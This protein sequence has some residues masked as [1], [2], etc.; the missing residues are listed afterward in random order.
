MARKP[1]GLTLI[2]IA[3]AIAGAAGYA[4]QI[5]VPAVVGPDAFV[6]FAAFWSALYLVIS[7]LSGVQQEFTRATL[8]GL[9]ATASDLPVRNVQAH[10][11]TAQRHSAQPHTARNFGFVASALVFVIVTATGFLWVP[12]VLPGK[13]FALA[14]PLAFGAASYVLVATLCGTLYGIKRFAALAWLTSVDSVLRLIAISIALLM[15][16]DIIG[17]AWAIALPFPLTIVLVW[18][19]IR[20]GLVGASHVDSGLR[21]LGWNSLRTVIAGAATGVII[22]GF[23]FLVTVTSVGSDSVQLATLV[24]AVTL[25]RAPLIIPILALQ[26]YLVVRFRDAGPRFW[27]ELVAIVVGVAALAAVLGVA[28]WLIGPWVLDVIFGGKYVIEGTT[29]GILV[30]SAGLTGALCVSGPAVLALGR[31][32]VFTAGWVV[33]AVVTVGILLLPLELDLKALLALAL[34]PAAGFLVHVAGLVRI[35][36]AAS[37][38]VSD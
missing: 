16:A 19:F 38:A 5:M 25:T 3:T 26:S 2:L 37:V 11:H 33:A 13:S 10:G 27:R 30:A 15:N 28:A 8:P 1:S 18:G 23:P 14:V 22:S 6:V 29:L 32:S 31:H 34:G 7:A 12:L 4:I 21:T 35:R 17:L 9:A 24:L 20:R 36:R